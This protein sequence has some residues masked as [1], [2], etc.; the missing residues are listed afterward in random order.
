MELISLSNSF[1]QSSEETKKIV[2]ANDSRLLLENCLPDRRL[3]HIRT[4][5]NMREYT[6]LAQVQTMLGPAPAVEIS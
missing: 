1:Y 5:R 6:R 4:P 3:I 2:R